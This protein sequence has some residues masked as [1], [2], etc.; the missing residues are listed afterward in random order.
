MGSGYVLDFSNT[1][2][3]RFIYGVMNIDVY[4]KYDNVTVGKLLMELLS[5]LKDNISI[6]E[7]KKE[8]FLNCVGIANGLMGKKCSDKVSSKKREYK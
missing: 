4:Q 8:L 5:Y 3:Q 2:F 6:K 1:K 7:Q